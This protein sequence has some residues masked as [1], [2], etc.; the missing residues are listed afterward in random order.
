MTT[1]AN[2]SN[3]APERAASSS[4]AIMHLTEDQID[5]YLIGSLPAEATL[6][7]AACSRCM[8][9]TMAAGRSIEGFRAVSLA[10]SERLSATLPMPAQPVHRPFYE[11]RLVW[12]IGTAVCA[13]LI[14][15]GSFTHRAASA[16]DAAMNGSTS[17]AASR[18]SATPSADQLSSDNQLLNTIDRELNASAESPAAL[19]LTTVSAHLRSHSS[20]SAFQD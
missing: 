12:S 17:V 15:L 5:D 11:P 2:L 8:E 7:L 18:P 13:L 4:V 16:P 19:G 14:G 20:E 6:H 3:M 9:R 1:P 10:W